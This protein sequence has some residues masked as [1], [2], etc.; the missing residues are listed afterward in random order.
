MARLDLS[1][2]L[3]KC[4]WTWLVMSCVHLASETF[5][6]AIGGMQAPWPGQHHGKDGQEQEGPCNRIPGRFEIWLIAYTDPD[7]KHR[8]PMVL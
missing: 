4:T 5:P 7:R 3:S 1:A 2:R 6:G 8:F